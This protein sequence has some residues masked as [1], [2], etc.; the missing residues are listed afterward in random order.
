MATAKITKKT[1]TKKT[2]VKAVAKKTVAKKTA[3]KKAVATKA[4]AKKT[5]L[6]KVVKKAARAMKAGNRYSC[7]VCGLAV[8]VDAESGCA[9]AA[10]LI[11]CD[12][13]MRVKR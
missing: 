2:S 13:P 5:E 3:P 4:V 7:D 6:K 10:Y 8:I 9:E 1:I 11:C 12:N